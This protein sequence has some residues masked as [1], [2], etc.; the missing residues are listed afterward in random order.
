MNNQCFQSLREISLKHKW[1]FFDTCGLTKHLPYNGC[2]SSTEGELGFIYLLGEALLEG[3]DIF[4]TPGV[5]RQ[6]L[7]KKRFRS[8]VFS[9]LEQETFGTRRLLVN[10]FKAQGKILRPEDINPRDYGTAFEHLCIEHGFSEMDCVDRGVLLSSFLL[11]LDRG[12]GALVTNDFGIF[13]AWKALL[14]L[15]DIS[16]DEFGLYKRR[17][18]DSYDRWRNYPHCN[19]AS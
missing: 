17:G 16:P 4:I 7:S 1:M 12:S 6:Y 15:N 11:V 19:L 3:R 18:E 10:L 9:D 5:K 14:E 8:G 13:K 2:G